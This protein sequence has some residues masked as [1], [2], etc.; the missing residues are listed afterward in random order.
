MTQDMQAKHSL[1]DS[2]FD[3]SYSA[4]ELHSSLDIHRLN[5]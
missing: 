1:D 3:G 5:L 2:Q 4:V